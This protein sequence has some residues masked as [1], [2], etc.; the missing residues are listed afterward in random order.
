MDLAYRLKLSAAVTPVAPW[1]KSIWPNQALPRK[2]T[3]A[4]VSSTKKKSSKTLLQEVRQ[5]QWNTSQKVLMTLPN[6]IENNRRKINRL[7]SAKTNLRGNSQ[8]T[9]R[10]NSWGLILLLKKEPLVKAKKKNHSLLRQVKTLIS[11]ICWPSSNKSSNKFSNQALNLITFSRSSITKRLNLEWK[12]FKEISK[13][14]IKLGLNQAAATV[15]MI[16]KTTIEMMTLIRSQQ[17]KSTS[18]RVW[19]CLISG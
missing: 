4:F 9:P 15:I 6:L 11:K 18:R 1:D 7:P 2:K 3:G 8:L 13:I 12:K 14:I 10:S 19:T 5:P 16:K 17:V